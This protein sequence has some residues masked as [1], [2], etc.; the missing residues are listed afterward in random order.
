[1]ATKVDICNLALGILGDP[2]TLVS[3]DPPEGS[4]E[5][6]HCARFYPM[7]KKMA[8]SS[9]S[10]GF[11]TRRIV[12]ACLAT[13]VVGD[14]ESY[15][16]PLPSDCLQV[17]AVSVDDQQE[18]QALVKYRI[19]W[20]DG[21]ECLIT[22]HKDIW[23]SYTSS[24]TDESQFSAPFT[25]ALSRLLASMLAGPM[26][27]GSSGSKMSADQ[28]QLYEYFLTQAKAHDARQQRDRE[29]FVNPFIGDAS[30]EDWNAI[31]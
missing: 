26:I 30:M 16:F 7:A 28:I 17:L 5:A 8:L 23:L 27:P 12:P 24:E 25:L 10:W 13:K 2:A 15:V 21:R 6:D 3:I 18:T 14:K 11:A 19:E 20:I 9:Y 22:R 1:M 31:D 29:E 4:A